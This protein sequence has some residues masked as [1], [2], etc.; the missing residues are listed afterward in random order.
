MNKKNINR[1]ATVVCRDDSRHQHL[2]VKV[3]ILAILICGVL[4]SPSLMAFTPNVI[5][6]EVSGE[7]LYEREIQ[8]IGMNGIANGTTANIQ[9]VQNVNEGGTTND[10]ILSNGTQNVNNGGV[11][12]GTT[13]NK[14]YQY[15]KDGGIA[16]GGTL[17]DGYQTVQGGGLANGVTI[18]G[19]EQTVREGG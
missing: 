1:S 4:N 14:G 13:I 12:N 16:N 3:T 17:N 18:N 5:E 10:T 6:Q 19:G 7:S 2:R 15:I 11:A 9:G 8:N